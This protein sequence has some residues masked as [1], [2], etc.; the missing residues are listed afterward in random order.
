MGPAS[1]SEDSLDEGHVGGGSLLLA[2]SLLGL[3][4]VP[5]S[6]GLKSGEHAGLLDGVVSLLGLLEQ[7]VD[8][9]F[10]LVAKFGLGVSDF[11]GVGL[12]VGLYNIRDV[13]RRA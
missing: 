8:L 4:G 2:H 9:G 10:L 11:L 7:S 3:P 13:M 1:L 12:E 5:L 6:S